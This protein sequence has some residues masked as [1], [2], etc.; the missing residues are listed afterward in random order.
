M[1]HK[2]HIVSALVTA[3]AERKACA[4]T[5][6]LFCLHISTVAHA[7][8]GVEVILRT[9]ELMNIDKE[10]ELPFNVKLLFDGQVRLGTRWAVNARHRLTYTVR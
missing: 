3:S 9:Y 10:A 2:L 5:V 6:I 8:Q 1:V 7:L 4:T